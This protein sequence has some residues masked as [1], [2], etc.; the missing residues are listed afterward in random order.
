M[1]IIFTTIS[2]LL[3]SLTI[4]CEDTSHLGDYGGELEIVNSTG[5]TFWEIYVSHHKSKNWEENLLKDGEVLTDGETYMVYLK[6]Y[7][8]PI[9]D[10]LVID[11]DDD[12]YTYTG[13]D[14]SENYVE[15]TI[16]DLDE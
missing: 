6:G 2:L 16:D 3:L 8:S 14:I 9:F 4:G 12:S 11:Q 10:I 15:I 5:H 7:A 1:R 13:V